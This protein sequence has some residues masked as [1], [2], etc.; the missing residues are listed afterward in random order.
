MT[1]LRANLP[2]TIALI[3]SLCTFGY[4]MW[5]YPPYLPDLGMVVSVCLCIKWGEDR[6]NLVQR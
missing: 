5:V 1:Y 2:P 3:A 6:N 4:L